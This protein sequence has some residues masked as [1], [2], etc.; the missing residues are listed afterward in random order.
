MAGIV[1]FMDKKKFDN[2]KALQKVQAICSRQEKC[3]FDISKKLVAWGATK[4]ETDEIISLLLKE[5]FIDE[6]RYARMFASEKVRFNKWGPKKVE[7][8]LR[9][10]KISKDD[11]IFALNE[12]NELFK[13]EQLHEI[14]LKKVKSIN[15]KNVFDFKNKLVRFGVSRGFEY[16]QVLREVEK[17]VSATKFEFQ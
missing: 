3:I 14:L 15:A 11:I 4:K 6:K 8:A 16:E 7:L 2:Q 9:V 5:N 13:P 12:I 17:I 1:S 10:K